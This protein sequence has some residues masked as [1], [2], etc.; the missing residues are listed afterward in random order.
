M[1]SA[2][3]LDCI[4]SSK[5][6]TSLRGVSRKLGLGKE[7]TSRLVLSGLVGQ[8]HISKQ[9]ILVG[10]DELDRLSKI[11]YVSAD[12]TPSVQVK[13]IPIQYNKEYDE[14]R[15]WHSSLPLEEVEKYIMNGNAVRF[16][17]EHVGKAMVVTVGG[18]VG[19]IAN[20]KSASGSGSS[21]L[22]QLEPPNDAQIECYF[23]K[24]LPTKQGPVI[25]YL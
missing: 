4:P 15:G 22:F 12:P 5:T 7:A 11:E 2:N 21:T 1:E 20:I 17:Q 18:F 23:G 25:N 16:P 14:Y 10:T 9:E 6:L 13:S 3:P 24:R 19:L 8:I